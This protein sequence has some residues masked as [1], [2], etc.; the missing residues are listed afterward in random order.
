MAITK[1]QIVD[2]INEGIV[3]ANRKYEGWTNGYWV[4]D[5]GVESLMVNCIAES[6]H[7]HQEP[8]ESPRTGGLLLRHQGMFAGE[9]RTRAPAPPAR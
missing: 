1:R 4:T 2:A 7:K 3:A 8:K 6:L 5:S 9:C